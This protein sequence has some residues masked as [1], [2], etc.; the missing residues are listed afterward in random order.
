[1]KINGKKWIKNNEDANITTRRRSTS[2]NL[3]KQQ[4]WIDPFE[5]YELIYVKITKNKNKRKW[6]NTLN[7][8]AHKI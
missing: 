1:M 3:K 5:V 2:K 4:K 7:K 6:R 8:N